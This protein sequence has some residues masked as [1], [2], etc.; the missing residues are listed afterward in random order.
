MAAKRP[1]LIPILDE[2]VNRLLQPAEDLFWVSMYDEL[3]DDNHRGS[4][5]QTCRNVPSYVSLLRRIGV[6]LWMAAADP[7]R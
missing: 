6:A 1:R 7:Q 4:I 5:E 2:R 3:I